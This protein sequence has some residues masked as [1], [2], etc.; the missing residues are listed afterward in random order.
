MNED[1]LISRCDWSFPVPIAYGPG[2]LREMG[3]HAAKLGLT[4]PLI[5][6]DQGSAGLP[7]IDVLR[8]ALLS[9][10]IGSE[11]FA[12]VAPNPRDSDIALARKAYLEGGHDS[13][14]AIGGGSGM[15]AGKATAL[16]AHNECDV[17]QFDYDSDVPGLPVDHVFPKLICIP[18]TAGTG[19]ETE[20]T[21][22]VTHS[23]RGMKLCIWHPDLKP[24]LTLLDPEITLG[25]PATLTAWTGIDAMV[26]AIEAYCVP[27][28]HPM[29]DGVALEALAL[30]GRWL[31]SAVEEPGN[32]TARGGMQVG[33][34]LAGVSFLK[35]L[36]L[37]HAISH[38]VGADFD[39]HHGLTNAIVLPSVLKFNA[40]AIQDKLPAMCRALGLPGGDFESLYAAICQLLDRL[41]VPVN[42]AEIGVPA[43]AARTLAEKAHQDAAAGTNPRVADV[44]TI[45]R[46]ILEA[47]TVGR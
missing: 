39:T 45:E 43:E 42:L 38:M 30:I 16:T 14:I 10:G 3:E 31:P 41:S 37:V 8:Q 12:D 7:F 28:Y 32:L 44:A 6:T 19:A 1:L 26:H 46:L 13:V 35:G 33:A 2:R 36:G 5:V 18:S 9:A 15:D 20:S 17:W 22:M 25:L 21:A 4:K 23:E 27:D 34:C 29:C 11:V 40:P 24:S 47:I